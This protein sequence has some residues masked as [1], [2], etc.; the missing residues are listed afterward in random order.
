[1]KTV[2]GDD[3]SM[4]QGIQRSELYSSV[5]AVKGEAPALGVVLGNELAAGG[6]VSPLA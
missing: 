6:F 5:N 2:F 4:G 3:P 1:M